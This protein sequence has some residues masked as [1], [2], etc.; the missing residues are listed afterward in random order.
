M[1]EI[2]NKLNELLVMCDEKVK[3]LNGLI[4]DVNI[5]M[6]QQK[7][8]ADQL[9]AKEADLKE[10]EAKVSGIENVVKIAEDTK[11]LAELTKIDRDEL[12]VRQTAFEATQARVAKEQSDRE[13]IIANKEDAFK[14]KEA[15]FSKKEQDFDNKVTEAVKKILSK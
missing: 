14:A 6:G 5:T 2:I 15:E 3:Q 8:L 4:N 10:R 11:A 13:T 1:Q 12:G 7:A 9:A